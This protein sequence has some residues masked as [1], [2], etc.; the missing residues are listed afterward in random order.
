MDRIT[1]VAFF[2]IGDTLASVGLSPS[3]EEIESLTAYPYVPGVLDELR[4]R[5]VRLG[6]LSHRGPIPAQEV[7]R[8]LESAGLRGFFE[9]DLVIYA[10]KDSPQVFREAASRAGGPGRVLFVGEDPAERAHAVAAGLL[11]APHPLLALPVLDGHGA[12]R[13]VRI[14]V[15]P[16]RADAG[17]ASVPRDLAVVPLHVTGPA[18][19]TVLAIATTTAAARLDD[20]G[21]GVD[22]LGAEGLPV[23]TGLYLLRDDDQERSGF[24]APDGNSARFF[25][26]GPPAAGVLA[27]SEDGLL[28]AIVSSTHLVRSVGPS[29]TR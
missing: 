13:F 18:G 10:R 25:E 3:G 28:V 6:V 9:P 1:A 29:G 7:D 2:D 24:L 14:T 17:R 5:G 15:P 27:S 20:L 4:G 22:R 23:T 8:A 16:S 19:R 11:A 26:T 21:F 12:L